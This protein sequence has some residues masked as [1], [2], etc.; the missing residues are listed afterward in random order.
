MDVINS[1]MTLPKGRKMLFKAFEIGIFSKLQESKQASAHVKYSLF[2]Y[3]TYKLSKKLKD[4]SPEN[5]LSHLNDTGNTDKKLL[6]PIKKGT[7]LKILT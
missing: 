1:A 5:I 4:I 6:T 3:D 2:R 7:G